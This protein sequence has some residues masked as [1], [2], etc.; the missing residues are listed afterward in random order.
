MSA[1]LQSRPYNK[2]GIGSEGSEVRTYRKGAIGST[3]SK[4]ATPKKVPSPHDS[5]MMPTVSTEACGFYW[6][7]GF[8]KVESGVFTLQLGACLP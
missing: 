1:K 7:L 2:H 6:V 4:V 8:R 5:P 3:A